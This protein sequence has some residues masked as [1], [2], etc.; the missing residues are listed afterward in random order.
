MNFSV[1]HLVCTI[2]GKSPVI[3]DFANLLSFPESKKQDSDVIF[4]FVDN[5]PQ[6]TTEHVAI[7]NFSISSEPVKRTLFT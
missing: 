2:T 5:L 1:G 3:G 4:E 7:G 6:W